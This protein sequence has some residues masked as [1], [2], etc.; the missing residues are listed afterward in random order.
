M[1]NRRMR[2]VLLAVLVLLLTACSGS[3]LQEVTVP[4]QEATVR[5][6]PAD[7]IK[8]PV[9]PAPDQGV[10]T[11][12]FEVSI[13][14]HGQGPTVEARRFTVDRREEGSQHVEVQTVTDSSTETRRYQLPAFGEALDILPASEK[15]S[16]T[17][18]ADPIRA[19]PDTVV[20]RDTV[21]RAKIRGRPQSRDIE[22][23]CP[24]CQEGWFGL[25]NELAGLG[26]LTILAGLGGVAWRFRSIISP[27]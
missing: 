20:Q 2:N 4:A 21:L 25:K 13:A 18:S 26:L 23:D 3:R 11:R 19:D 5:T 27:V 24:E 17:G 14:P 16:R 6:E 7:T 10:P 15:V 1:S 12:P 22:A 8:A 9:A